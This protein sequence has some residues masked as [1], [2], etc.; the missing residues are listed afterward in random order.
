MATVSRPGPT[1]DIPRRRRRQPSLSTVACFVA[2]AVCVIQ[3]YRPP[4]ELF[5]RPFDRSRVVASLPEVQPSVNAFGTSGEVKLRFALPEQQVEY[6]LDVSG[7]ASNVSY[8]WVRLGDS[9]AAG[10]SAAARPLGAASLVAPTRPGLYQLALISGAE[11]ELVQGPMLAV[12]VPF[13]QKLGST[14]NGYRIGTYLAERLGSR[15]RHDRPDG[16]IEVS[17]ETAELPISK[18]FRLGD[19]ITRDGQQSWPRYAALN[20]RLLD[21]LELVIAEVARRR[22]D[23]SSLKVNLDV[24][25]GFRTPSYNRTVSRSAKDSRHQYGDAADVTI[26]ANFDGRYTAFDSRLVATA[27]EK[28][29]REHPE[30]AGGLGLYTSARYRTPYVHI[31]ARGT[32][33][34]WRG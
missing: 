5:A 30:L 17:Q 13:S 33:A 23:T 27:V 24:Q 28:V 1:N 26:D 21:K 18:H 9:T 8:V 25:S 3:F 4:R 15:G 20:P 10:D 6:P 32:R 11:R 31:D 19:F 29:E 14:L 12:M 7:D 22:G 34:R 2:A 16:F